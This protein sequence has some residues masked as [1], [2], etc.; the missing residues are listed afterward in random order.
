MNIYIAAIHILSAKILD[1]STFLQKKIC[2]I[3]EFVPI[4]HIMI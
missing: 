3:K 1:V 4:H 2:F